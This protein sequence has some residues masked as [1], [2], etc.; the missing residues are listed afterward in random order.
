M[1]WR[2]KKTINAIVTTLGLPWGKV[3]KHVDPQRHQDWRERRSAIER[4]Y[5]RR[6]DGIDGG[7]AHA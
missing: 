4:A 2:E 3:L 1:Y 6:R 7:V 5:K